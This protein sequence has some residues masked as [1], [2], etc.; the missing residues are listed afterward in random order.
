MLGGMPLCAANVH[1]LQPGSEI[2]GLVDLSTVCASTM[3]IS[4]PISLALLCVK[5]AA[6]AKLSLADVF[7]DD[8]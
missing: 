8:L 4:A 5:R 2:S 6:P 3:G 1:L 7:G